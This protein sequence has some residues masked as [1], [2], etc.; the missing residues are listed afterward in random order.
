[1]SVFP[2]SVTPATKVATELLR[3]PLNE[4]G[5]FLQGF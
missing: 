3:R 5:A 4:A 2:L 1:M